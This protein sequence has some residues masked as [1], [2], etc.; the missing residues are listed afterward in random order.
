M[1]AK[2]STSTNINDYEILIR[3]RGETDYASYCPQLNLMLIGSFHEEVESKMYE[4]IVSHIE[5]LKK[6]QGTDPSNN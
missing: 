3:R 4:K 2:I 6:L 5:E 1:S